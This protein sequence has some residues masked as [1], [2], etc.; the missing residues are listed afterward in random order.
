MPKKIKKVFGYHEAK[1]ITAHFRC[2]FKPGDWVDHGITLSSATRRSI[3][4]RAL[5]CDNE[6]L[7]DHLDKKIEWVISPS[8]KYRAAVILPRI[9]NRLDR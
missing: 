4:G 5:P 1:Y 6:N 7:D 8:S 2:Q 3:W 9:K